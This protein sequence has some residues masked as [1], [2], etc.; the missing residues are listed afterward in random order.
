[1]KQVLIF[2]VRCYRAVFAPLFGPCCRFSPSCS[3]YAEEALK[4]KGV[5]RGLLLMLKRLCKCH[6][7]HPGGFD[8]VP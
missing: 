8:P 6:P 7:F 5:F 2:L 3:I 1:M 4:Q